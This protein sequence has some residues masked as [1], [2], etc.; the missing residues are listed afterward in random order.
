MIAP[1]VKWDHSEEWTVPNF[2]ESESKSGVMEIEVD[3]SKEDNQYL[4]G[5]VIDGQNL[6][7]A[8]AYVV[9]K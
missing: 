2:L 1:Y 8:A 6:Y 3:M 4:L 9:S 5:H 7:P